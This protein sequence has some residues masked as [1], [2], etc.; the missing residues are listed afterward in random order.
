MNKIVVGLSPSP[1]LRKTSSKIG[2]LANSNHKPG[3]GQVKIENRKLDWNVGSRTVNINSSYT[4]GG[5]DK[6][7]EQRKLS[8]NVGSKIGSLEKAN[9][10]PGGGQVRIENRRLD[11]NVDSK[12]GSTKNINHRPGGGNIQ[13]H[14]EKVEM[15]VGSRIGSL[16]NVKHKPGGGDKKIFDDKEYIR[17]MNEISGGMTRFVIRKYFLCV[18]QNYFRSGSSSLTGSTW[19][20]SGSY[21][22]LPR[23]S[24]RS[25]SMQGGPSFQSQIV[26]KLVNIFILMK[27]IKIFHFCFSRR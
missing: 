12:V 18:N 2:S 26:R 20:N 6:K 27:S 23:D 5:G 22:T 11:W 13:I 16:A 8:W 25:S 4:P 3:G 24:K 1:N 7:I 19:D 17:Q 14:N 9:H 10:K 21:G 15:N